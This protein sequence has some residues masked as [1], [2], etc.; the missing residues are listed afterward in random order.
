MSHVTQLAP[1]PVLAM[2]ERMAAAAAW[3]AGF[4][5]SYAKAPPLDALASTWPRWT[6]VLGVAGRVTSPIRASRLC[7]GGGVFTVR[8]SPRPGYSMRLAARSVFRVP[9]SAFRVP[10]DTRIR[11]FLVPLGVIPLGVNGNGRRTKLLCRWRCVG[12]EAV[13]VMVAKFES[14]IV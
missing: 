3:R 8:A 1:G 2:A 11:L 9:S 12:A 14:R 10:L 13:A 7:A 4:A 5:A 6:P